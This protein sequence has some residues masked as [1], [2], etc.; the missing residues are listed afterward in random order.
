MTGPASGTA[1]TRTVSACCPFPNHCGS[2]EASGLPAA[3]H[4]PI[5]N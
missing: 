4:C 3:S 1:V 2:R 5:P